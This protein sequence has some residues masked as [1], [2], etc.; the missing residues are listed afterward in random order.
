MAKYFKT[1][2][3]DIIV[4]KNPIDDLAFQAKYEEVDKDGKKLKAKKAKKAKK[5]DE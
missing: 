2:D 1:K 5:T 4:S 3:G